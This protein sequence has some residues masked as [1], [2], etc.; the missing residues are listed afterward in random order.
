LRD[1][2]GRGKPPSLLIKSVVGMNGG[3]YQSFGGPH[4]VF[5]IFHKILSKGGKPLFLLMNAA[6]GDFLQLANL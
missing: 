2:W 6:I 5:L 3:F 4:E 1:E